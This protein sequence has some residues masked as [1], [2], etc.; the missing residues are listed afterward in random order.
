MGSDTLIWKQVGPVW[1]YKAIVGSDMLIWKQVGLVWIYK[2]IVLNIYRFV[3][4]HEL[5]ILKYFNT[6]NTHI[7]R[8]DLPLYAIFENGHIAADQPTRYIFISSILKNRQ[9]FAA[10]AAKF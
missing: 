10:C 1:I 2:A 9:I 7:G 6:F 8:S 4:T 5:I 3:N